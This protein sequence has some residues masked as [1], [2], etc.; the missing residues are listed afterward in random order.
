MPP[1]RLS[2]RPLALVKWLSLFLILFVYVREP[3]VRDAVAL[4]IRIAWL[5]VVTGA[6]G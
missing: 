2:I 3:S 4:L 5:Y 6:R 1:A